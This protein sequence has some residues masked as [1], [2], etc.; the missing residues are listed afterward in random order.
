MFGFF[1]AFWSRHSSF[2]WSARAS[3]FKPSSALMSLLIALSFLHLAWLSAFAVI[4]FSRS[5]LFG[6]DASLCP[7]CLYLG[8]RSQ[9]RRRLCIRSWP[10]L[11]KVSKSCRSFATE[12]CGGSNIILIK[13]PTDTNSEVFGEAVVQIVAADF[14]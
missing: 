14:C 3:T 2:I 6:L 4:C 13:L 7:T 12:N 8:V 1:F 9:K 11:L 10:R 5:A